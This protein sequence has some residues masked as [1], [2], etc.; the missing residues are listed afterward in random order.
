MSQGLALDSAWTAVT[1]VL[2][3]YGKDSEGIF[4]AKDCDKHRA[5][6]CFILD[7]ARQH[8]QY[9]RNL[10]KIQQDVFRYCFMYQ[11]PP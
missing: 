1:A 3:K 2:I 6:Y 5:S 7:Y 10:K 11:C 8:R 9:N 4:S